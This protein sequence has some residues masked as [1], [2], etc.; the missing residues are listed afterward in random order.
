MRIWN[1]TPHVVHYD[2]GKTQRELP[3]D[4]AVR[5]A[6]RDEPDA[7][8]G[9]MATVRT[10]YGG[11]DGLPEELRPGDAVI[12]ST[13]VADCWREGR[14]PGVVILTPNTGASCKRD[15][16]GRIIAVSCFI[17]R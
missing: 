7:P 5:L 12:V 11:V 13:I 10:V 4:G 15:P 1:L 8:I 9:D 6:Q 14:P 2:D 16:N 17:R 3:S